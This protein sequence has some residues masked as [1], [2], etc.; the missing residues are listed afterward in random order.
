ML[1]WY[2]IIWSGIY[3]P[4]NAS[5]R[6]TNIYVHIYVLVLIKVYISME[7]KLK[8]KFHEKM[9]ALVSLKSHSSYMCLHYILEGRYCSHMG[10]Y[11]LFK[12]V[13][14]IMR[15][16]FVLWGNT[17]V[18]HASCWARPI[19]K[20]HAPGDWTLTAMAQQRVPQTS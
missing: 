14:I 1:W 17:M 11:H 4:W 16:I 9:C 12:F 2:K 19:N 5:R 20:P 7:V 8:K 10:Y 15:M 13:Y 6:T 18:Q 3:R